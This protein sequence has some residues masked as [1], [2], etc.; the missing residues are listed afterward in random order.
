M[1]M[2]KII[3]QD[4]IKHSERLNNVEQKTSDTI[5]KLLKQMPKKGR[6]PKIKTNPVTE[7]DEKKDGP[8]LIFIFNAH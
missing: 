1:E 2:L 5:D 3:R 4:Q 7:E 8:T 6:Q